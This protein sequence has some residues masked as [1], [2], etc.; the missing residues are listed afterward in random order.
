LRVATRYNTI[1]TDAIAPT[2]SAG[3]ISRRGIRSVAPAAR[4]IG[5][6]VSV[7]VTRAAEIGHSPAAGSIREMARNCTANPTPARAHAAARTPP[8]DGRAD[9]HVRPA[10]MPAAPARCR[11]RP[12]GWGGPPGRRRPPAPGRRLRRHH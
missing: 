5:T 8:P 9:R 3:L 7:A 10:T 2:I 1:A 4:A 6:I 12:A 11:A